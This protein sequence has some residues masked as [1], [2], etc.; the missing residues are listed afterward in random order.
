MDVYSGLRRGDLSQLNLPDLR[1][2]VQ[3]ALAT[4]PEVVG[5]Y[6]FGSALDFVRSSSD[7]DLGLILRPEVD[8][9]ER[10]ANRVECALGH[11][12]PHPFQVT[13]LRPEENSFTFRVLR[14]GDLV[15]LAD[16]PLVTDLIEAVGRQHDDLAP[17]LRTFYAALGV[18]L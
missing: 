3:S 15:Y 10:V 8:D 11:Y 6:L 13:L 14:D 2:T 9:A 5:A 7:I 12:G 17:F 1:R 4:F 18:N 16:V